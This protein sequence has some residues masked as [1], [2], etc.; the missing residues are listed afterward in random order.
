M[1]SSSFIENDW[2]LTLCHID[3]DSLKIYGANPFPNKENDL[4]LPSILKADQYVLN[5]LRLGSD[6]NGFEG[7]LGPLMIFEDMEIED[8]L[9]KQ[10]STSSLEKLLLFAPRVLISG[11]LV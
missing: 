5:N 7:I 4:M 3:K 10:I 9:L 8:K 1:A 11:K 6:E 2:K